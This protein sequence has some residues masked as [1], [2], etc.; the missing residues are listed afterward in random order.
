MDN[1]LTHEEIMNSNNEELISSYNKLKENFW[2]RIFKSKKYLT[3]KAA[4]D[5]VI[6]N[7]KKEKKDIC[8][9]EIKKNFNQTITELMK[10]TPLSEEEQEKYLSMENVLKM[11]VP[12]YLTLMNRLSGLYFSHVTRFGLRELTGVHYFGEGEVIDSF[13][14]IL[15]SKKLGSLANNI[16]SES[17]YARIY[18]EGFLNRSLDTGLARRNLLDMDKEDVIN[19][20]LCKFLVEDFSTDLPMPDRS[21][22][23]FGYNHILEDYGG[24]AD[25][26]MYFYFPAEIIAK[27]FQHDLDPMSP[28]S[29]MD[30]KQNDQVVWCGEGGVPIDLGLVCIPGNTPVDRKTG[31]KY[32]IDKNKNLILR[33]ECAEHLSNIEDI[34]EDFNRSIS[35]IVKDYQ[36]KTKDRGGF[37]QDNFF[38]RPEIIDIASKFGFTTTEKEIISLNNTYSK[39]ASDYSF[40]CEAYNYNKVCSTYSDYK[41][42]QSYIDFIMNN[43]LLIFKEFILF[44]RYGDSEVD[45]FSKLKD[46]Y[47]LPRFYEKSEED[48]IAFRLFIKRPQGKDVIS[49]RDYWESFFKD[50]PNMKPSKI[51]YYDNEKMFKGFNSDSVTMY[52]SFKESNSF[53]HYQDMFLKSKFNNDISGMDKFF[54]KYA[55]INKYLSYPP[56]QGR[57][58]NL[59]KEKWFP[60][61][62]S[63]FWEA[64]EPKI[65]EI[66]GRVYDDLKKSKKQAEEKR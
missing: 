41:R 52:S 61:G 2:G 21:S 20:F 37:D 8:I 60:A 17:D 26:T 56:N 19:I 3:E 12:D 4:L 15:K 43:N 40:E 31:S 50:N 30:D 18:I 1:D 38:H 29:S 62:Y 24:E 7:F 14:P 39:R 25:N 55:S 6:S 10:N 27:N 35:S 13:T 9:N 66:V 54:D 59:F 48:N 46:F 34:K 47:L 64:V 28:R 22:I 57:Y 33:D 16:L 23:H 45:Y 58:N 36:L 63:E 44:C 5:I 51:I 42:Q 32:S 65:R 49:S 53:K 11:D